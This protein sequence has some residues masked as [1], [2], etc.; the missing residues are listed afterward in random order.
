MPEI[1]QADSSLE[2]CDTRAELDQRTWLMQHSVSRL[3]AEPHYLTP[4]GPPNAMGIAK[5][6]RQY[7][8]PLDLAE[9]CFLSARLLLNDRTGQT[10]TTDPQRIELAKQVLA[11]AMKLAPENEAYR[12][13][14]AVLQ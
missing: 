9:D 13:L 8:L 2:A 1:S 14:A 4:L 12:K 7:E 5:A 3:L 6:D 10:R 11:R